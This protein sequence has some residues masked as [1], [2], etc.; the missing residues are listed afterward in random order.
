MDSGALALEN[1]YLTVLATF[2]ARRR[3]QEVN[4][5]A[6]IRDECL[7]VIV[8]CS[9]C[10]LAMGDLNMALANVSVSFVFDG[11][12]EPLTPRVHPCRR[13]RSGYGAAESPVARHLLPL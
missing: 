6:A 8:A 11:G 1:Y 9:G 10:N 12:V 13:R 3:Q 5:S 4:A 7:G 2:T